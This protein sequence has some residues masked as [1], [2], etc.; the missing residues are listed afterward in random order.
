[1][2]SQAEPTDC[3]ILTHVRLPLLGRAGLPCYSSALCRSWTMFLALFVARAPTG[4]SFH[5]IPSGPAM[6]T[7]LEL[8]GELDVIH[9]RPCESR[10]PRLFPIILLVPHLFWPSSARQR[11]LA[12]LGVGSFR[13]SA[14]TT[15]SGARW[16][17]LR[18]C[19]ICAG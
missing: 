9:E 2:S 11:T 19:S 3:T 13:G 18:I 8:D 6:L 5:F 1:M 16:T 15:A 7:N 14:S 17:V 4:L 10:F 12:A